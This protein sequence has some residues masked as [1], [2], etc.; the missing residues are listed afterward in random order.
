MRDVVKNSHKKLNKM[1]S[2]TASVVDAHDDS[3]EPEDEDESDSDNEESE[4]D[5]SD[6]S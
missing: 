3:C 1:T 4:S 2:G 5:K 6:N